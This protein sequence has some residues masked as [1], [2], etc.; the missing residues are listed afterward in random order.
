MECLVTDLERKAKKIRYE[1]VK[2]VGPDNKG[3]IGGSCSIADIMSALY[4]YKMKLDPQNPQW[5]E[6][7]RLLLSKGHAALAQYVVL[8]ELGYFPRGELKNLKRLG[9]MLQGHPDMLKT[10]GVEANTGSLGQGLSIACGMALGAKLD[11]K[12]YSVYCILGDGETQ[13]GQ[14]W[15]GAMTASR[16][17]LDN[18]V[19]ILDRN[20]LQASGPTITGGDS[21]VDKWRAFG[22]NVVEID[23]HDMKQIVQTLDNVKMTKGKPFMIIAKTIKGKGIPFAENNP[24]FHNGSMTQAEYEI[25]CQLLQS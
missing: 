1:I 25:A 9:A 23:G 6:R 24:A 10:S 14:I 19:A 13:E 5:N 8:A 18:L 12:H 4:F 2:M 20:E 7:D 15:E 22:W 17:K 3:H 21:Q 11:K 16:F